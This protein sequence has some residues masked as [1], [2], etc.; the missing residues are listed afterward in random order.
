[1]IEWMLKSIS[2]DRVTPRL[3]KNMFIVKI[4]CFIVKIFAL[5]VEVFT[6][7]STKKQQIIIWDF[8]GFQ[9]KFDDNSKKIYKL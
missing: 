2:R 7:I 6:E 3:S 8:D 4:A 1:M 9:S 5:K